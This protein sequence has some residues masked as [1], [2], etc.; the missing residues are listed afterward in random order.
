MRYHKKKL[1]E[2]QIKKYGKMVAKNEINEIGEEIDFMKQILILLIILFLNL[3]N[4]QNLPEETLI[5]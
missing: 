3:K 2:N 4:L 1:N 5:S